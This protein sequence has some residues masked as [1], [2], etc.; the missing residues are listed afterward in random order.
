M[1][2]IVPAEQQAQTSEISKNNISSVVVTSDFG[3]HRRTAQ[4]MN[5]RQAPH[6]MTPC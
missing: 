1:K 3:Y 6:E 4:E 2:A 5:I